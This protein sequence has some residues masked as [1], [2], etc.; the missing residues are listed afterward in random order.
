MEPDGL[1]RAIDVFSDLHDRNRTPT[2]G[3]YRSRIPTGMPGVGQQ[4][5]FEVD[6]DACTGCKACVVACHS[7]NGL[8]DNELWRTVGLLHGTASSVL[9]GD[10]AVEQR[11]V[12]SA[13]HLCASPACLSGC[14]ANAYEKHDITGAV[15]HLDD[16]CIGCSYCTMTCPYDVPVFNERLSIVRKCDMCH[17]RLMAG[18]EPACVQGCPNAAIRI[19]IVDRNDLVFKMVADVAPNLVPGAPPSS[20]T[21]PSTQYLSVLDLASPQLRAVQ[22][23][24]TPAAAHVPLVVMLIVV[25]IGVGLSLAAVV[26]P[27]GPWP[28]VLGISGALA[29]AAHLGRPTQAWRVVL[30]FRHSW[31]SR[32]AIA[33]GAFVT[34]AGLSAIVPVFPV[35]VAAALLGVAVVFT[36]VKVYSVTAR[37]FWKLRSTALR[38][39][40]GAGVTAGV[41]LAYLES[42]ANARVS[43]GVTG[44]VTGLFAYWMWSLPSRY[45]DSCSTALVR[46]ASLLTTTLR[47]QHL[48]A[49]S[50]GGAATV[51]L[52]GSTL[53][54][55]L[56]TLAL[57]TGCVVVSM[58]YERRLFFQAVSP[59]GM[60]T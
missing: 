56:V 49:T 34:V 39:G 4:F 16:Q 24:V 54:Q 5:A 50:F 53:T 58:F 21:K 17:G 35:R 36:S 41:A 40:A 37:A 19:T 33:I 11:T 20:L 9:L 10:Q 38:F 26:H 6:L 45:T 31:L 27:L 51:F 44:L 57:A 3:W 12:T 28:A 30:G 18:E 7:L 52:F 42:G 29:S 1:S 46:S 43:A 59:D 32:E 13:C 55:S 2:T 48:L 15:I 22:Q 23:R 25:Q 60:P 47:R 14:P 8:D